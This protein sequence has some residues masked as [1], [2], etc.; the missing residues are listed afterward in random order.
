MSGRRRWWRGAIEAVCVYAAYS[1]FELLRA[2]AAG[3]ETAARHHAAQ[4]IH[5]ERLLGLFHEAGVQ[6]QFLRWHLFIELWDVYYGTVHFVLP[7]VALFVLWR[8]MPERY[9]LWRNAFFGMLL[10]G[11]V[12]FW[13]YPLAP[14][15]LLPE[16]F[17]FVDTAARIGGMGPFD[18]GSMKDTE[19][20]W[21]AMPSL[22]IGWSLWSTLALWPAI[23]H[24][25]RWMR[26]S[27]AAYPAG[28][29]FAVVVTGNHYVL[30]GVGGAVALAAGY[31]LAL[32][33][34]PRTRNDR[35]QE[36]VVS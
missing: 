26:W 22:H 23:R 8:W 35:L 19:N 11:L 31:G 16:H 28:T 18:S 9:R 29:L 20:L 6:H 10:V 13:L 30:D 34:T 17:G 33:V 1:G 14:P 4:V 36:A 7:A 24:R 3:T 21:A 5:A 32:A 15:R 25:A 2:K 27:L 12:G